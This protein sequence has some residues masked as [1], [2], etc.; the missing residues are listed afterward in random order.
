MSKQKTY[1]TYI[2][3]DEHCN[4]YIGSASC[5]G[6]PAEHNYFGSG[7]AIKTG[8]FVPIRKRIINTYETRGLAGKAE[9]ALITLADPKNNPVCFNKVCAGSN[10][11][12]ERGKRISEALSGEKHPSFGKTGEKHYRFDGRLHRFIHKN[13]S[14]VIGI[15][16]ELYKNAEQLFGIS[17]ASVK[18][19]KTGYV[20][21]AKGWQ[22]MGVVDIDV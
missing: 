7:K 6:D 19:L 14:E 12:D 4:F 9:K 11:T 2:V 17:T 16:K 8:E 20:Q 10:H 15:Y 18:H 3:F 13:G 5:F 22:Y 1:Y 21:S